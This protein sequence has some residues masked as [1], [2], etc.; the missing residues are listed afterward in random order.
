MQVFHFPKTKH[1][2]HFSPPNYKRY[3]T[4]K[5]VL[6]REFRR[7]CVYCRNV[8]CAAPNLVFGVDH[9]RPKSISKFADL[10]CDYS[11]LYYC[12]NS[13]NSR[14]S[15]YWPADESVGPFIVNPCDF[16]MADHLRYRSETGEIE[17]RTANGSHT[18]EL[19]Q[20]NDRSSVTFRKTTDR[21]IT[22]MSNDIVELNR[23]IS[24][25]QLDLKD[26]RISQTEFDEQLAEILCDIEAY[27]EFIQRNTG[28]LPLH[29]FN[30][31]WK[32]SLKI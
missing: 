5:P 27:N 20:L 15:N 28:S 2:R 26:G 31:R 4:Y 12:C 32:R 9:Y 3:A 10:V 22:K 8:D 14:K 7:Q 18:I 16:K 29:D 21:L 1:K 23:E 6:V 11:N 25:I 30:E 24:D 19:L 13:C 17:A